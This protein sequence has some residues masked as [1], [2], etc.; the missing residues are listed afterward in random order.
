MSII[1]VDAQKCKRDGLCVEVCPA[2]CLA[3]DAEGLPYEVNGAACFACG[4]CVA[5]CPHDALV[6]TTLPPSPR[7]P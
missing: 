5:V 3:A 2:L 7:C 1:Q 6:N 4:H